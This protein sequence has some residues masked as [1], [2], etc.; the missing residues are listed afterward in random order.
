MKEFD[1]AKKGED[2]VKETVTKKTIKKAEEFT[3]GQKELSKD[4]DIKK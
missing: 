1:F 2:D 3:E 4:I